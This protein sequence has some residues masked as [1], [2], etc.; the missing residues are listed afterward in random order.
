MLGPCAL[1]PNQKRVAL[2]GLEQ[3]P[4]GTGA[5]ATLGAPAGLR[6]AHRAKPK[7][8]SVRPLGRWANHTC[9]RFQKML[10]R[11]KRLA[12]DQKT[13]GL[14][15]I[16]RHHGPPAVLP[17]RPS[18]P[19]EA[20]ARGSVGLAGA[21]HQAWCFAGRHPLLIMQIYHDPNW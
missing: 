8:V 13:E 3:V 1:L 5:S 10:H 17:P 4:Q 2:L 21:A 7:S 20:A 6:D 14:E 12:F 11:V 18:V 16:P 15:W 9:M 19:P